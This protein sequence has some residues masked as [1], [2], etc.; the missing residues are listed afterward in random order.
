MKDKRIYLTDKQVLAYFQQQATPDFWDEH[1]KIEDLNNYIRSSRHE[2]LYLPVIKRYL[3]SES[4]VLEG[5]CGR[6]QLVYALQF[7]GYRAIGIDFSPHTIQKIK[8]A[9]PELDI[10]LGDVRKLPIKDQSFDGYLS[11]G[12]IEHFWIGYDPILSEIYRTLKPGGYLFITF[13]YMSLLRQWKARL[14]LYSQARSAFLDNIQDQFF[15]FALNPR[16]VILDLESLGFKFLDQ[17]GI[18]GIKGF[19]D[20]VTCPKPWLQ[21]IYDGKRGHRLYPYLDRIFRPFASHS[22]MLVMQK[23]IDKIN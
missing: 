3:P 5:G 21:E 15:Q 19:K 23:S 7:Q 17:F 22:L 10:C 8:E 18:S 6:G 20:E 4:L 9:V 14:G 13:P 16:K 11:L 12:L 2:N 1:W